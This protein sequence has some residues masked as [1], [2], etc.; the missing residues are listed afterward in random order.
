[1]TRADATVA[2]SDSRRNKYTA[3]RNKSTGHHIGPMRVM[4]AREIDMPIYKAIKY[5]I[6][7]TNRIGTKMMLPG[8][9][10]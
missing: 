9:P 4:S 3:I 8:F 1:M 10:R 7:I 6:L 5:V 2:L